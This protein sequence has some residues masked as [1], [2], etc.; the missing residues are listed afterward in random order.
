MADSPTV[1]LPEALLR[2]E[3]TPLLGPHP[4]RIREALDALC[5]SEEPQTAGR[6]YLRRAELRLAMASIA[7]SR[8]VNA[9][10]PAADLSAAIDDVQEAGA[11]LD[12]N[13]DHELQARLVAGRLLVRTL[14]RTNAAE[15]LRGCREPVKG[16]HRR[17][18][19]QLELFEGELALDSGDYADAERHLRKAVGLA[20]GAALAHEHYQACMALAAAAQLQ[21][22]QVGAIPWL[23]LARQT[24]IST[25]DAV[26]TGDACFTLGN[27]LMATDDVTGSERALIEAVEAG[28][29]PTS[30]P[31]ALMLLARIDL[32]LGH[33]EEGVQHAVA[34]A[35]AGAAVGNGAAFADGSIIAAQ[36][37]VGMKLVDEAIQTLEAGATVLR[38]QGMDNFA[39]LC[40]L[41]KE[42]ILIGEG[43]KPAPDEPSPDDQGDA[44]S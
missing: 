25:G 40:D 41:Q 2:A 19:L 1:T 22:N 33:F 43:R 21:T 3:Q 14:R 31:M 28:L 15:L 5:L 39:D 27:L 16:K 8:P 6:A 36:C 10:Q 35:R 32:G 37:Q 17:T 26:R 30:L 24:A 20:R 38:Q 23:R 42:E 7:M 13:S 29:D 4:E 34:S 11:R 9:E 44:S 18:R 12:E